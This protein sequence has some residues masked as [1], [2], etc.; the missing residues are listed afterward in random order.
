MIKEEN[1]NNAAKE[2]CN[3][4]Y[5]SLLDAPFIAEGFRQGATWAL[6]QITEKGVMKVYTA[7]VTSTDENTIAENFL[8]EQEMRNWLKGIDQSK[9]RVTFFENE[10]I[11]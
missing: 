7:V 5:P 11:I 1:I 3:K 4:R 6:A 8:S 2:Y 10:I 9:N